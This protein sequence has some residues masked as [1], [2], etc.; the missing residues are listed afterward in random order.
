[1]P[2]LP[3]GRTAA[4]ECLPHRLVVAVVDRDETRQG[5]TSQG[6]DDLGVVVRV[7]ECL[8]YL[9]DQR[10]VEIVAGDEWLNGPRAEPVDDAQSVDGLVLAGSSDPHDGVDDTGIDLAGQHR[11]E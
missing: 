2:P 9:R 4:F 8:A 10:R 6:R 1:M 11:I 5:R 3:E 7:E